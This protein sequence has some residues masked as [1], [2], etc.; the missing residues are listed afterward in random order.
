MQRPYEP[1]R[2]L[3][4]TLESKYN[5][6][7]MHVLVSDMFH[8]LMDYPFLQY[9]FYLVTAGGRVWDCATAAGRGLRT[10]STC[11]PSSFL[12]NNS[13][14]GTIPTQIGLLTELTDL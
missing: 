5:Q 4:L 8:G 6:Y 1:L 3:N 9:K 10:T 2:F 12:H 7:V 14:A 11:G 13:L